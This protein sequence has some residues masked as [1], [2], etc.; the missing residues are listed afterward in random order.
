MASKDAEDVSVDSES[1]FSTDTASSV[2]PQRTVSCSS[3]SDRVPQFDFRDG[4][5]RPDRDS[6]VTDGSGSI[7]IRL[8]RVSIATDGSGSIP[9]ELDLDSSFPTPTRLSL[10]LEPQSF[11]ERP[12]SVKVSPE[13]ISRIS[14]L[15][16][17]T[18]RIIALALS[19][20][21]D[22]AALLFKHACRVYA[23][24]GDIATEKISIELKHKVQW[25]RLCIGSQYLVVYGTEGG[26]VFQNRVSCSILDTTLALL[27]PPITSKTG[28]RA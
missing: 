18:E 27:D 4:F 24:T 23:T 20:S 12:L 25:T 28:P 10:G 21:G 17:D 9:I 5:N 16:K 13:K 2:T 11:P 1:S 15:I 14:R 7:P 26:L 6:V 19:P 8:D 22:Q 3:P